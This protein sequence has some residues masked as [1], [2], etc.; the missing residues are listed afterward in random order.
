[1]DGDAALKYHAVARVA[2]EKLKETQMRPI[3]EASR[4]CA[5]KIAA[6]GL[7][8]LFG[9][10]HSRMMVDEMTPRQGCFVGFYPMV[11]LALANYSTVGS[12]GL[13]ACLHLEKYEGYAE[14]ILKSYHL[15]SNDA[16]IIISTSGIRPVVVE[17]AMAAKQRKLPVIAIVSRAHCDSAHA[18]HS[19]GKKLVDLADVVVDNLSPVGDCAVELDGLE[20]RTGPLSTMTGAV[21]INMIRC[22]TAAMLVSQGKSPAMLPS[23][24]FVS[25]RDSERQL[26]NF[27]EQYRR[28]M[29]HLYE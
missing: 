28:S 18:A 20:S 8:F 6:S 26:E 22:E 14:Q 21:I 15:G 1:M 9:S 16:F 7:V 19:S 4:I 24:Q 27:Y 17:M 3:I 10:G 23:H 2:L 11:E 29:K 25:N 12:N 5:A 13:R